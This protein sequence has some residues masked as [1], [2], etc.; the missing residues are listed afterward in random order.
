M[1][2][3]THRLRDLF[4]ATEPPT[5]L[6]PAQKSQMLPLIQAMLIEVFTAT[7]VEEADGDEDNV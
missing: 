7:A 3:A 2:T 4:E 1:R 5:I 6:S